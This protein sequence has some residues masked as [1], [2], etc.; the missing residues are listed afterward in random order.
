MQTLTRDYSKVWTVEDFLSLGELSTPCQLV[1]GELIMSPAPTPYHQIVLGN[2]YEL[3][4]GSSRKSS[5]TTLFAPVDLYIDSKNVFQPDL[6][7]LSVE[8]SGF[9]TKKGIEGPPDLI[10]EIISPSNSYMDRY[11]KKEAY[12]QFGVT[13]YWIVD[14]ANK[15]LEIYNGSTW[16][17]PWLYL[18]NEGAVKSTVL[19]VLAFDLNEIF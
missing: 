17:K 7:Y 12:Q 10:V 19:S 16:D 1:N 13:E 9:L 15:T 8:R 3:I 5:G 18:A 2:L 4:K 6:L 11:E 14:P